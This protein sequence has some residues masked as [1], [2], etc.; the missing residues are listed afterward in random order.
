M[1]LKINT[2]RKMSRDEFLNGIKY[3][4]EED[5]KPKP[6]IEKLERFGYSANDE[7]TY[8]MLL[9]NP[10]LTDGE[11][12]QIKTKIKEIKTDLDYKINKNPNY[13]NMNTST[14]Q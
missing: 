7:A 14:A 5:L 1:F 6:S 9:A 8:F 11:K 3:L 13:K 10:N 12:E 4:K 2:S